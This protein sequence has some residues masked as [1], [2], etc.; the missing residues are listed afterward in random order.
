VLFHS[1]ESYVW[2]LAVA[3]GGET[4]Y[5]GTGPRGR[6][7]KLT[8]QGKASV[9]YTTKQE[10]I[11][12]L[13]PGPENTLYAGTDKNGLVYRFDAKGKGFVLYNAPQSE[14]RRLLLTPDGLYA[15]TSAPRRRGAPGSGVVLGRS[16]GADVAGVLVSAARSSDR[17][18]ALES[19]HAGSS[20][21]SS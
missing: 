17:A 8:P 2:C 11:L 6:I 5:A 19:G 13:T 4:I 10:H 3:G 16:H 9:F 15:G 7:Y 14:L 1:P 21:G 18:T 20:G 12:C